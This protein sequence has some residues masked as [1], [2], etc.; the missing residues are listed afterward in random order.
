V[1]I[2]AVTLATAIHALSA[3]AVTTAILTS[4]AAADGIKKGALVLRSGAVNTDASYRNEQ[5]DA[6]GKVHF[7]SALCSPDVSNKTNSA[8]LIATDTTHLQN[9]LF[10]GVYGAT[11]ASTIIN[12]GGSVVTKPLKGNPNH[13]EISGLSVAKIKGVWTMCTAANGCP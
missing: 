12:A 2:R 7:V 8:A 3:L 5:K 11:Q 1:T 13:C 9:G 4:S 10:T 6:N